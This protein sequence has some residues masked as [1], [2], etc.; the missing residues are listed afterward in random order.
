MYNESPIQNYKLHCAFSEVLNYKQCLK[1][2][3]TKYIYNIHSIEL[4]MYVC[5]CVRVYDNIQ[6]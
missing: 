5:A 4:Y 3:V 1:L 2:E 6:H